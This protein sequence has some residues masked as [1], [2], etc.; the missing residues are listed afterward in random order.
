MC[1]LQRIMAVTE[2]GRPAHG[3]TTNFTQ[4]LLVNLFNQHM[5]DEF[6]FSFFTYMHTAA[7]EEKKEKCYHKF[8]N[9]FVVV[10]MKL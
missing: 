1:T 2:L 8:S 7:E 10:M 5:K 9:C 6:F 3:A 4:P